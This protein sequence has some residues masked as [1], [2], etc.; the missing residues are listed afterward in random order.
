MRHALCQ[1]RELEPSKPFAAKVGRVGVFVVRT[2]NGR[3]HVLRD[4]CPHEGARLSRGRV[5]ECVTGE[6]TGQ[7]ELVR[8]EFVIRCPWHGYEF[9]V[10]TG[11]CVADPSVRVRAYEVTVEDGV[12]YI[13]R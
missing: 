8:D 10:A 2:P 9:D 11:R 12:V 7:Y 1:L 13:D 5:L 6:K 3:I 4:I